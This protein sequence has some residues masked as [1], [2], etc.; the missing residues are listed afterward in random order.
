MYTVYS[1]NRP[2]RFPIPADLPQHLEIIETISHRD[3]AALVGLLI[4]AAAWLR[5]ES[6][7]GHFRFDYPDARPELARSSDITLDRA[8]ALAAELAQIMPMARRRP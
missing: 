7:G 2:D 6:R 1:A 3:D 4:A 5:R 8:R